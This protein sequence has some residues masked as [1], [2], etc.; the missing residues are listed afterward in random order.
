MADQDI[1]NTLWT[2]AVS[3]YEKRTERKIDKDRTFRDL[4]RIDDLNTVV[5]EEAERFGDFRNEN[6][7]LYL[8]MAKSIAPMEPLLQIIQKGL[9][10]SPYTPA[11]VVLGAASYLMKAC[12]S[13]S[14]A[15]DGIEEL[16]EQMSEITIRL[17][18]Y[19]HGGMEMSLQ[20][21]MTDIL[22]YF[23]E[24]IGE[25][26]ACIRRKRFKEWAKAVFTQKDT[27]IST[28]MTKLRRYVEAELGLVI[29]LTYRVAKE[30]RTTAK[31][32]LDSVR[33][34]KID[35]DEVLMNQRSDRQRAF[36][37]ADERKLSDA[38]KTKTTDEIAREHVANVEK[39]TTNTGLWIRDDAM[40]KA[41]EQEQAPILWVF[42]KPG[43]GKTML[44]AR[45]IE[46][47]QNKYPQHSD[48][49]H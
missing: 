44:A 32:A 12:T 1:F 27:I 33:D 14:K 31:D 24:I 39:L 38:L 2:D 4:R 18:E 43:F 19:E 13:V 5:E 23:L 11:C 16:F 48:I 9:G 34:V 22:A 28:T 37:E 20:K 46:M 36:S 8:A 29:A 15:Y 47:L 6:R 35:V 17:R 3:E 26:E 10:S 41:W 40:F 45:T 7:R 49:P 21:K 42:G 30:T 25:A